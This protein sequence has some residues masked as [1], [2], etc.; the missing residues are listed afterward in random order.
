MEKKIYLEKFIEED[1]NKYY[2]L[3]SNEEVM[4]MITERAIPLE[5]AMENYKLL[6]SNNE[7]NKS[8]LLKSN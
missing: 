7:L 6:L 5:E 4:A 8:L 2:E 1:F 3:V